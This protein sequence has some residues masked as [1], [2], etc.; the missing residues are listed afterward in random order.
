MMACAAFV[1]NT[2]YIDG[3]QIN[4]LSVP[5]PRNRRK[6]HTAEKCYLQTTAVWVLWQWMELAQ[7]PGSAAASAIPQRESM[8][9]H[10]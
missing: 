7:S 2:F 5:P 3:F 1:Y 9:E 6:W 4:E 10:I 8:P